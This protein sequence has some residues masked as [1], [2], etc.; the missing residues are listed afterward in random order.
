MVHGAWSVCGG[1]TIVACKS[2]FFN[3]L[4]VVWYLSWNY[5][6]VSMHVF[7]KSMIGGRAVM[8]KEESF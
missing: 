7:V 5:L 3:I 4:D 6:M 1:K 8:L 2:A